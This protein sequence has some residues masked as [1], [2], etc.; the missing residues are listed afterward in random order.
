M[1]Y[2]SYED[3]MR[4]SGYGYNNGNTYPMYQDNNSFYQEVNYETMYPEIYKKI[5]PIVEIQCVRY[6]NKRVSKEIVEEIAENVY[7][8]YSDLRGIEDSKSDSS[9]G[10][11]SSSSSSIKKEEYRSSSTRNNI[12]MDL[13]KILV[14]KNLIQNQ[15]SRPNRPPIRPQPP[16]PGWED[17]QNHSCHNPPPPPPYG[18]RYY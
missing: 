5:N 11:Q 12:L 15:P 9:L 6:Q 1:Y 7:R 13:I 8:Q 10:K 3:F 18:P 14:I 17:C 16:Y 2:D 4:N